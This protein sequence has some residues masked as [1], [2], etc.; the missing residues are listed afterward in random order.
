M[1]TVKHALWTVKHGSKETEYS[2]K[3][4]S[5]IQ[6][7]GV[8]YCGRLGDWVILWV[9][10]WVVRY[11]EKKSKGFPSVCC[12]CA[13]RFAICWDR[14]MGGWEGDNDC[15]EGWGGWMAGMCACVVDG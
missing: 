4:Q 12:C 5:Y 9:V 3:Q 14:A 8:G 15:W 6:E 10:L 1:Y 13:A 2:N 11:Q 7:R